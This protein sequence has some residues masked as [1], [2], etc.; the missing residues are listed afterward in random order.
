MQEGQAGWQWAPIVVEDFRCVQESCLL[1][2][3]LWKTGIYFRQAIPPCRTLLLMVAI[4]HR[5]HWDNEVN[6]FYVAGWH[7]GNSIV[8]TV[9]TFVLAA[10]NADK[11][12]FQVGERHM[13]VRA[14]HSH[15]IIPRIIWFGSSLQFTYIEKVFIPHC[16][17]REIPWHDPQKPAR[18]I[19]AIDCWV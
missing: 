6:I 9:H 19:F 1:Y 11:F 17:Q 4:A 2:L 14:I 10:P 3:E 12:T 18:G 15:L 8:S 13:Y 5:N 16:F 7:F